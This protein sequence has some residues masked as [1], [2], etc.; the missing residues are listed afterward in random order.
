[1]ERANILIVGAG[2]AG[3]ATAVE[4]KVG[5]IGKVVVLE[6][7]DHICDTIVRLYHPGKRV[8]PNFQDL[9]L[10]PIGTLSFKTTTKEKFLQFIQKVVKKYNLDI[11][12]KHTV[13]RVIKKND[14]FEVRA[15][16]DY[17]FKAPIVVLAIGIFGRPVKP[18]Y[19]IPKEVRNKVFF[20]MPLSGPENKTVLVVGGGNTAAE[21]AYLLSE[22]NKVFLSYRRPQFFRLNPVNMNKLEEKSKQGLINLLL[23]TD[24]EG[25]E[26]EGGQVKVRF[27]GGETMS[28]DAIYYCLGG[29][30]PQSFLQSIGVELEGK[31]PKI[32]PDGETNVRGLFLV[33][34]LVAEKGSIMFAFNS[35]KITVDGILRKY[36]NVI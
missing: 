8:D 6:K 21:T 2:P 30:T 23:N 14:F 29:A 18:K 5:G 31:R 22:K 11:R 35:A 13:D 15:G 17:L 27:K 10:K 20:G 1:M 4:A 25:I 19:K 12:Y 3:I 33:G 24:I 34:D 16:K 32:G 28:F 7:A 36:G 9:G 26:P